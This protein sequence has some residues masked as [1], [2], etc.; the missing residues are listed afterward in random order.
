[1]HFRRGLL[2]L[3]FS[4]SRCICA[5]SAL[6]PAELFFSETPSENYSLSTAGNFVAKLLQNGEHSQLSIG[7][8]RQPMGGSSVSV[9]ESASVT[10][11]FWYSDK[12]FGYYA[13]AKDGTHLFTLLEVR[14]KASEAQI[15]ISP[16]YRS[17]RQTDRLYVIGPI[18][19]PSVAAGMVIACASKEATSDHLFE[20]NLCTGAWREL[21]VESNGIT[22][23]TASPTGGKLA[24][25]RNRQKQKELVILESGSLRVL[26]SCSLEDAVTPLGF[27][28]SEKVLWVVSNH[29]ADVDKK[30][31][32]EW[33]LETGEMRV[34]HED[35]K[36]EVDLA[37]P[38]IERDGKAVLGAYYSRGNMQFH[39]ASHE[40]KEVE[41]AFTTKFGAGAVCILGDSDITMR[42]WIV[43]HESDTA[44]KTSYLF[45][46]QTK[47]WVLLSPKLMWPAEHQLGQ[48]RSFKFK[49][50]DGETLNGYMTAQPVAE[51]T[52]RPTVLFVHGG[53]RMRNHWGYDPRVQFLA[54][55]GYVVAQVNFRGSDGFGKA[56]ANAGNRQMGTGVMQHDLTDA[57]SHLIA[58]GVTD[59][60]RVAI[61][62]GSYGGYAALAGMIF[63]PD[64]FVA[65]I[66]FFGLSDL[67]SYVREIPLFWQSTTEEFYLTMG[68]PKEPEGVKT[69]RAQ[70]PLYSVSRLSHPVM[71]LH[72]VHDQLV[73]IAQSD[74]F[75]REAL[76]QGKSV[77]YLVL[78]SESHGFS[79]SRNEATAFVAIEKFL[80]LHLGGLV[81]NPAAE[82]MSARIDEWRRAADHRIKATVLPANQQ[83]KK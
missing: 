79:D 52:P 35:P 41:Q 55:R 34:L 15:E 14:Q 44:P 66:D 51:T 82:S 28:K 32:E 23:W 71:I 63:T 7:I 26:A 68:N 13:L 81:S 36:N 67:E 11:S 19:N 9:P 29:G 25:I 22:Q 50:R 40:A 60:K 16:L 38:L 46:R 42:R 59:R 1:M 74:N 39:S 5:E 69:M 8:S 31:L 12:Q 33:N 78:K 53:P 65:G 48:M 57:V 18:S 17:S 77:D 20:L 2:C 76:R 47:E 80:H 62:G 61:F 75:V 45:D 43:N 72:G 64:L 37:M 24:G 56:F 6:P 30:R 21:K 73:P 4:F 10:C 83:Y 54:S 70:S 27:D 3:L 49:G 58:K